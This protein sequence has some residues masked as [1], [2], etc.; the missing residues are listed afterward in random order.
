[1]LILLFTF[2]LG[3]EEKDNDCE[4]IASQEDTNGFAKIPKLIE[5]NEVPPILNSNILIK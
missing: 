3:L 2:Y 5:A 1:M 4:I